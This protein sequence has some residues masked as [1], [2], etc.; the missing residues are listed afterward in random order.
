MIK[1][2]PWHLCRLVGRG[3]HFLRDP[4]VS[5]EP[6]A[7]VEIVYD[8]HRLLPRGFESH[9][10][11]GAFGRVASTRAAGIFLAC[12]DADERAV[13]YIAIEDDD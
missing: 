11:D 5:D 8:G 4:D 12:L 2:H 1:V 9:S 3:L 13:A 10:R 7:S 6:V